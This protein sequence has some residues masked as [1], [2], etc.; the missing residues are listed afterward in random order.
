MIGARSFSTRR[1]FLGSLMTAAFVSHDLLG[2]RTRLKLLRALPETQVSEGSLEFASSDTKLMD[3]FRWAKAQALAYVRESP[4]IGPWYEAALPGRNDLVQSMAARGA[5]ATVDEFNQTTLYL[6]KS[7][8]KEDSI[9][10]E[11]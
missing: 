6:S 7:F 1:S 3:G 9:R 10:K 2:Q 11:K 8:P 5:V 4:A